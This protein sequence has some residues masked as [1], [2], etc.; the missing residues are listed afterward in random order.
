MI[1]RPIACITDDCPRREGCARHREA[2]DLE[3]VSFAIARQFVWV[4]SP[5]W[6]EGE[7]FQCPDFAPYPLP[8]V[9]PETA[10]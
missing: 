6:G 3:R 1:D 8:A 7:R 9:S 4:R 10:P 2:P 5:W